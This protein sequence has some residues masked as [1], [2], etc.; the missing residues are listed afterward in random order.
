MI[1]CPDE[2]TQ[3]LDQNAKF[4]DNTGKTVDSA[5]NPVTDPLSVESYEYTLN[6]IYDKHIVSRMVSPGFT[7]EPKD[8]VCLLSDGKVK[9]G[10][11]LNGVD[12]EVLGSALQ[13]GIGD[14]NDIIKILSCEIDDYNA[15]TLIPGS[16]YYIGTD[17]KLSLNGKGR[18][19]G[20][21]ISPFKIKRD[22]L[23]SEFM[24]K[25]MIQSWTGLI[26]NPFGTSIVWSIAYGNG[27]Y[28][29]CGDG[30][31][32]A[33]STD[34]GNT[35]GSLITNPFGSQNIYGVAYGDGVFIAGGANGQIARSTDNGVSWDLISNPFGTSTI[36]SIA[37]G[38][39]VFVAGAGTGKIARSLDSGI[40]WGSLIVNPFGTQNVYSLAF[41]D[42]VFVSVGGGVGQ[43][44]RSTDN[45][46]S[47]ENLI[48]NQFKESLWSC[49][50]GNNMF[51]VSS[52]STTGKF[53]YSLDA[54]STWS[55]IISN[56]M[57]M[58][59][60]FSI[61][62]NMIAAVGENGKMSKT[63]FM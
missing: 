13:R 2:D 23:L 9:S 31:K 15:G 21:A 32:I 12:Y 19:Y 56:S 4:F 27:V 37:Y 22:T 44:S 53:A 61:T 42:N 41:G 57:E 26:T 30:G 6:D 50:F 43:I 49:T 5:N 33:R 10:Y 51:I 55:N 40:T 24:K 8:K 18:Y 45:G 35:W 39:G 25:I 63:I 14:N 7:V 59:R 3:I 62:N 29:A 1:P 60:R 17:G 38:N 16:K 34:F 11:N 48:T 46:A 20:I 54:G 58:I 28:V 47:W 52:S 36:W